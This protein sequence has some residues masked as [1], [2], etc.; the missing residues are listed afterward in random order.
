MQ[1]TKK[2]SAFK[3]NHQRDKIFDK[4]VGTVPMQRE[5]SRHAAISGHGGIPPRW[6]LAP[7]QTSHF[8][9]FSTY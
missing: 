2:K 7:H 8:H 1:S 3:R 4:V 9:F 5:I 6:M